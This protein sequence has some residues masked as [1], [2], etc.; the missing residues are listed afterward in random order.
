MTR[1]LPYEHRVSVLFEYSRS[2][3]SSVRPQVSGDFKFRNLSFLGSGLA[4]LPGEHFLCQLDGD[5]SLPDR[6]SVYLYSIAKIL[7]R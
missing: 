6:A 3:S 4:A 5:L 1:L 7:C 2:L